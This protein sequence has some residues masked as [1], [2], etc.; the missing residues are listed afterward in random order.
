MS[1]RKALLALLAVL[2]LVPAG[3]AY[4][5]VGQRPKALGL[6]SGHVYGGGHFGA[7]CFDGPGNVCFAHPRDFSVDAH[8]IA[9]VV[10]GT[11]NYGQGG[12]LI[13]GQITCMTVVGNRAA[14]GGIVRATGD[15]S[16]I[17]TPFVV[18]LVDNGPPIGSSGDRS[19]AVDLLAP[20]ET[21]PGE[22][23]GFPYVCPASPDSWYGYQDLSGGDVV[24]QGG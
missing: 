16:D 12:L 11:L 20:G 15:G 4:S 23:Q 7:G 10:G 6:L 2:A 18:Q 1:S 8:R 14:M 17:G 5:S 13:R 21:F 9:G 19:G 3:L 22:P 24:V